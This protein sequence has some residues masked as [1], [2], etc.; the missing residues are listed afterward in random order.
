MTIQAKPAAAHSTSYVLLE[1]GAPVGWLRPG[2]IGFGGFA[3]AADSA[4]AAARAVPELLRW[5]RTRWLGEPLSWP[6]AVE[7][8]AR[9]ECN[10]KMVG[11]LLPAHDPSSL[12]PGGCGFEPKIPT[13]LWIGTREALCQRLALAALA[14]PDPADTRDGNADDDPRSRSA[15]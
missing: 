9:V 7:A 4:R 1:D 11:R 8:S 6:G 2:V 14:D 10:G 12:S 13:G 3:T 5:Y 15:G